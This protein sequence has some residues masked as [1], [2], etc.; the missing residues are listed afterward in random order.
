[1]SNYLRYL[2]ERFE[3]GEITH[4][5]RKAGKELYEKADYHKKRKLDKDHTSITSNDLKISDPG[6]K[7]LKTQTVNS[8][9]DPRVEIDKTNIPR[10][11]GSKS[12]FL[13]ALRSILNVIGFLL[14]HGVNIIRGIMI[15]IAFFVKR[16]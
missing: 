7:T 3:K 15:V 8:N 2:D 13:K 16:R 12:G 5:D 1:M 6:E 11:K 9:E 4:S 14:K 10:D